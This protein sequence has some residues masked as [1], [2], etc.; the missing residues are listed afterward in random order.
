M[1]QR[2]LGTP[3]LLF[4]LIA[5]ERG[6]IDEAQ[7]VA[8]LETWIHSQE[9]TLR[10]ILYERGIL[11]ESACALVEGLVAGQLNEEAGEPAIEPGVLR[12]RHVHRPGKLG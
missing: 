4:G 1:T 7:L 8:A 6:L 11:D 10:A 3:D 5:A 9:G 12:H 2:A